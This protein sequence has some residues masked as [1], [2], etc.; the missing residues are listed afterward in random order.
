MTPGFRL[1]TAVAAPM[2]GGSLLPPHAMPQPLIISVQRRFDVP[3]DRVFDAWLDPAWIGR[4]MFGPT[5]RDERIVGLTAEP[6]VGG[7]F[8]FVVDRC[9]S[10]L[11]HH[12]EYLAIDRPHRLAFTWGVGEAGSSTVTVT[13]EPQ[14]PGCLLTVTHTMDPAWSAYAD[15]TRDGWTFLL[16]TLDRELHPTDGCL[17][18]IAPDTVRMERL[19][20]GPVERVWE[21]LVDPDKRALWLA[22]GPME[23]R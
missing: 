20:P 6:R 16:G 2:L 17:Q 18:R 23:L 14:G 19:F 10:V 5:V 13:L 21:F 15:R 9:G 3:A 4:W 22:G 11:D 7:R 8:S 12:G 1:D